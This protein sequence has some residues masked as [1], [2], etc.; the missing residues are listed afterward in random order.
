MLEG[1]VDE[2]GEVVDGKVAS[3]KAKGK[4]KRKK[5]RKRDE[6]SSDEGNRTQDEMSQI[7]PSHPPPLDP[8]LLNQGILQGTR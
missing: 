7:S 8:T 2:N 1:D 3:K 4:G 5:K 6:N